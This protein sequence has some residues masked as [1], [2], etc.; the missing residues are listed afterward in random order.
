VAFHSSHPR[1]G[2]LAGLVVPGDP[3][4]RLGTGRSPAPEVTAPAHHLGHLDR[5]LVRL[6]DIR[7]RPLLVTPRAVGVP[8]HHLAVGRQPRPLLPV[9]TLITPVPHNTINPDRLAP[10]HIRQGTAVLLP[11]PM[12]RQRS[13]TPI[14]LRLNNNIFE[15]GHLP[16]RGVL[17]GSRG[18]APLALLDAG[19]DG[20]DGLVGAED[21][22][23]LRLVAAGDAD[24]LGPRRDRVDLGGLRAPDLLVGDQPGVG[25]GGDHV[26]GEVAEAEEA[27]FFP[28]ADDAL[29]SGDYAH[30]GGGRK[31]YDE[32]GC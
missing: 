26:P 25:E 19:L 18:T 14:L 5:R 32:G 15:R 4:R 1:W 13:S 8:T 10:V 31:G 23:K 24:V 6:P 16:E 12:S 2:S 11:H 3:A 29:G 21:G 28:A 17:E 30:L 20:G 27:A 22:E 9:P 7:L